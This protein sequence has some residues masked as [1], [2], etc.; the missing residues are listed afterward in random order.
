MNCA[1]K[2]NPFDRIYSNP[3]W[4]AITPLLQNVTN[5][6]L[7]LLRDIAIKKRPAAPLGWPFV[8]M[9]FNRYRFDYSDARYI[10]GNSGNVSV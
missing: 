7:H 6:L 8:F 1:C 2:T 3:G 10:S 9:L 4:R 5:A